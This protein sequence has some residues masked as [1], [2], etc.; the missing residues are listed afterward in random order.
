MSFVAIKAEI[1]TLVEGVSGINEVY[2]Y[3]IN[4]FRAEIAAYPVAVVLPKSNDN[5]MDSFNA[6]ITTYNFEVWILN[7]VEAVDEEA[8]Q[9]AVEAIIDDLIDLFDDKDNCDLNGSCTWVT[10]TT[11]EFVRS[12]ISNSEVAIFAS[13]VLKC[14]KHRDIS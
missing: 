9:E 12:G 4:P 10:P 13:I 1:K 5:L 8:G 6:N 2:D 3:G 14:N 11:G 7:K